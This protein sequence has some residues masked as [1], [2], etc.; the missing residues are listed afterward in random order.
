MIQKRGLHCK[1][2]SASLAASTTGIEGKAA[3]HFGKHLDARPPSA[4]ETMR[5]C[6]RLLSEEH[7]ARPMVRCAAKSI[8]GF[9]KSEKI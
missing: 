4:G 9:E 3:D 6:R 2:N 5:N 1:L 8:L 7:L